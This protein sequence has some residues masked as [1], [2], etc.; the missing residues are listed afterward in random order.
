VDCAG[1]LGAIDFYRWVSG[2]RGPLRAK[3]ASHNEQI[4][5]DDVN[6]GAGIQHGDAAGEL[7]ARRNRRTGR[8]RQQL[9][10]TSRNRLRFRPRRRLIWECFDQGRQSL[11]G[12][13]LRHPGQLGCLPP[14]VEVEPRQRRTLSSIPFFSSPVCAKRRASNSDFADKTVAEFFM[15]LTKLSYP[16]RSQGKGQWAR[17][18]WLALDLSPGRSPRQTR[19]LP[20]TRGALPSRPEVGPRHLSRGRRRKDRPRLL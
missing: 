9:D 20:T 13:L 1:G 4:D 8:R 16:R 15:P 7:I 2:R 10:E 5:Q 18:I 6:Y 17:G 19:N 11:P 12:G 14:G 3:H